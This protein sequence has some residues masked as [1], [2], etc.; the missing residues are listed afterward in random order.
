MGLNWRNSSVDHTVGQ[1]GAGAGVTLL[2]AK[3]RLAHWEAGGFC[4]SSQTSRTVLLSALLT[5]P[6]LAGF[7]PWLSVATVIILIMAVTPGLPFHQ[8]L[9]NCFKCWFD[10]LISRG[11]LLNVITVYL[12]PVTAVSRASGVHPMKGEGWLIP[13]AV[14]LIAR[15]F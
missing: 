12:L 1:A 10:I 5:T 11:I 8:E 13:L 3:L 15:W 9:L 6:S 2:E 7:Q 14:L 4:L